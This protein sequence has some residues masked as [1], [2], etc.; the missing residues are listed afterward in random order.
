MREVCDRKLLE[1]LIIQEEI[2]ANFSKLPDRIRLLQ[3]EKGEFLTHPMKN[4]EQFFII[5]N[6]TV[7]I[8]GIHEDSRKL[9][10]ATAG[11][12]TLLGD[13]EFSGKEKYPFFTEVTEPVLCFAIPFRENRQKLENDVVFLRYVLKHMARKLSMSTKMEV[14]P[15]TLEEKVLIYLK[16]PV[17]GPCIDGVNTAITQLHCSRRQLQRVLKKLIEEGKI[18]KTGRGRYI[19]NKEEQIS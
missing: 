6:G 5:I 8:Y 13:M 3:F 17:T 12:G 1:R 7:N 4:L 2:E 16:D 18:T 9:N 14:Y 19:L 15:Q 11:K 10:V